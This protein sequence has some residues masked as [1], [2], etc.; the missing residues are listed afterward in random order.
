MSAKHIAVTLPLV[1]LVILRVVYGTKP[2][3]E[4]DSYTFLEQSIGALVYYLHL[5]Q[6]TDGPFAGG[7]GGSGEENPQ[8]FSGDHGQASGGGIYHLCALLRRVYGDAAA[9]LYAVLES[10]FP[11]P[12]HRRSLAACGRDK[13]GDCD[14]HGG[15]INTM[16][17]PKLRRF[18]RENHFYEWNDLEQS[19]PRTT[20]SYVRPHQRTVKENISILAAGRSSR[21]PLRQTSCQ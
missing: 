16:A 2:A 12:S 3:A 15:W 1:V 9:G 13:G 5:C 20:L 4:G 6:R 19:S 18:A 14:L 8:A 11:G 21:S 17:L 10:G 7:A